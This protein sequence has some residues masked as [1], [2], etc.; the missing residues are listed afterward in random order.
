MT[1]SISAWIVTSSIRGRIV[2]G[3]GHT[4]D[5]T[6]VITHTEYNNVHT[7]GSHGVTEWMTHHSGSDFSEMSFFQFFQSKYPTWMKKP[8]KLLKLLKKMTFAKAKWKKT[9]SE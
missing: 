9:G 1:S 3:R 7:R 8:K 5:H 2:N 6:D 4:V